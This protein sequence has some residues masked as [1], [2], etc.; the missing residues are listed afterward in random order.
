MLW[1]D[2]VRTT[3]DWYIKELGFEEANYVEKWH[4]GVVVKDEVEIMLA[5]PNAHTAYHGPQFTGSLYLNTDDVEAL[6]LQLKN[7]PNVYYQMESF[8]YGMKEFAIRDL[9]GYIL[10]FGQEIDVGNRN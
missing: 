6:W 4:W 7:S 10:Q 9:N 5:K 3:I 1:V 8:D 2:D